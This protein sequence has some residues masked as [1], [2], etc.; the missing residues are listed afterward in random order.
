MGRED[1]MQTADRWLMGMLGV[2]LLSA[3]AL[4]YLVLL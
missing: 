4:A 1:K 2:M 3:L